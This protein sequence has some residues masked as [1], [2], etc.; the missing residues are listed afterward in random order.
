MEMERT[1]RWRMRVWKKRGRDRGRE[2]GRRR[3]V[4]EVGEWKKVGGGRDVRG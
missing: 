2:R 4:C 1:G 3:S